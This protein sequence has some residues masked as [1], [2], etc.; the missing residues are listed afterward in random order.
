MDN[1]KDFRGSFSLIFHEGKETNLP[2]EVHGTQARKRS[3]LYFH[4]P[5]SQYLFCG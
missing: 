1:G 5:A 3:R 2:A 4:L